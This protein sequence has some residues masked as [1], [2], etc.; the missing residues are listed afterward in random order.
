MPGHITLDIIHGIDHST[1]TIYMLFES[2]EYRIAHPTYLRICLRQLIQYALIK[3]R[4][5]ILERTIC[6]SFY[7]YPMHPT[8]NNTYIK[9]IYIAADK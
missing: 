4:Y 6:E 5:A 1:R 7:A 3:R 2:G 9:P 8:C